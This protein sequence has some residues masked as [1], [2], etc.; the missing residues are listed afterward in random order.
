MARNV[1]SPLIPFS[2]RNA[3]NQPSTSAPTT[4]TSVNMIVCCT[5]RCHR[6]WS[7]MSTKFFSPTNLPSD[8]S[9]CL[10]VM[11]SRKFQPSMPYTNTPIA[12]IDGVTRSSPGSQV[13]ARL[14]T[15]PS[16]RYGRRERL[17]YP[18]D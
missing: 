10:S 14:T 11:A 5:E 17:P 12:M 3:S 13:R 8:T 18:D 16:K 2:M 1:P 7:Q 4:N 6:G 15:F 9:S